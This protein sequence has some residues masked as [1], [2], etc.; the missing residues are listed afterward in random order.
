MKKQHSEEIR[1]N[2][3]EHVDSPIREK[4]RRAELGRKLLQAQVKYQTAHDAHLQKST[5]RTDQ[6]LR[7]ARALLAELEEEANQVLAGEGWH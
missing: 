4:E 7:S 3:H 1:Q 2:S 5:P 6:A